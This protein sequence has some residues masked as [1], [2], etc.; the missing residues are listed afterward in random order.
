MPE[1]GVLFKS[2]TGYVPGTYTSDWINVQDY[3]AITYTAW[4]DVSFD[5]TIQWAVSSAGIVIDTDTTGVLSNQ[6]ESVHSRVKA[7]Y[8][9]VDMFFLSSPANW[10]NQFF[11]TC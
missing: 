8:L 10:K 7:R 2:E 11:F 9:R 6:T 5:M 1:L 4:A 3:D